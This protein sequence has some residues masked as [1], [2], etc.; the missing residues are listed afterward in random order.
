MTESGTYWVCV[1]KDCPRKGLPVWSEK[2]PDC[3]ICR[4]PLKKK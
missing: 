3:P 1:N 2:K 4:K